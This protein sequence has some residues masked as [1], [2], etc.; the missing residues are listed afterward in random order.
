MQID[1]NIDAEIFYPNTN[2][3]HTEHALY[4]GQQI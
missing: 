1:I 4:E 2:T 3:L